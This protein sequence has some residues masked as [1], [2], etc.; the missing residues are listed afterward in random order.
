MMYTQYKQ[1]LIFFIFAIN[2]LVIGQECVDTNPTHYG[3]CE[4]PLGFV[5]TGNSCV[6]VYGCDMG[7]DEDLFYSTYEECDIICSGNVSLG[8]LNNDSNINVVDIVLLVNIIL[9]SE[10]FNQG[11]DI[12]FDN[13]NNVID[14]VILLILF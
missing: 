11:G 9:Q 7:Q 6:L 8:D 3:S 4:I 12:N 10:T 13:L 1:I 2:S 5:W 14:I